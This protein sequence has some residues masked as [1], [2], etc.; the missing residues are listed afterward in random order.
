M[1]A[2]YRSAQGS[3]PATASAAVVT[4]PSG[5]VSGDLLV[6]VHTSDISGTFAAMTA[7]AGWTLLDQSSQ[8]SA[9][10]MKIWT[11]VAGGSEGA[12]YTFNDDTDADSC[13]SM[14][15]V[16]TGTY[17]TTTPISDYAFGGSNTAS[18]SHPAPSVTGIAGALLITAHFGGSNANAT[19][20][21]TPPSG[22][23]ERFENSASRW[24]V[25]GTNTLDL[26]AG[27]ATGTKTATCSASRAYITV[28]LVVAPVPSATAPTRL[29][30]PF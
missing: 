3:T 18:V 10:F 22:M 27:G 6:C 25:M 16:Q 4:K 14:I 21:Y 7:P 15:A 1:A 23:S 13:V 17:D 8:T 12:S 24:V 19:L 5:V 30:L 11:R 28:S 20:T 2:T 29:F 9:G 26:A